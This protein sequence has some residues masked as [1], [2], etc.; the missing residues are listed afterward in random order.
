M[1]RSS[2]RRKSNIWVNGSSTLLITQAAGSLGDNITIGQDNDGGSTLEFNNQTATMNVVYNAGILV[3]DTTNNGATSP[4]QLLFDGDV[5]QVGKVAQGLSTT[6]SDSFIDNYGTI[7]RSNAGTFNT[8]LPI[9]NEVSAGQ[10]TATLDVQSGLL[11]SGNSSTKTASNAV[12][13]LGGRTII[14]NGSTLTVAGFVMDAGQLLTYGAANATIARSSG[15]IG[16]LLTVTGGTMQFSA[17][18][19]ANYGSLT[20]GGGMSWTGGTFVCY[21]NGGTAGQQTQLIMGIYTAALGAGWP[22]AKSTSTG[23]YLGIDL[24][25]GQ[26]SHHRSADLR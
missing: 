3:G 4:N 16:T 2:V 26:R 10:F 12:D 6:S 20:V 25:A 13:Q 17:D 21:V 15:Y 7:I 1:A 19:T 23:P 24:G 22:S 5:T 9:R 11:V 8:G 18:N 14:E